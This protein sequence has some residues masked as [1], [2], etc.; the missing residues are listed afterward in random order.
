LFRPLAD[1]PK[2]GAELSQLDISAIAEEAFE[3][4]PSAQQFQPKLFNVI[5]FTDLCPPC[6]ELLFLA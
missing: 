2:L 6:P 1:G 3:M 5:T 4:L